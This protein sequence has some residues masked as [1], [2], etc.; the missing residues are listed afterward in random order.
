MNKQ[1]AQALLKNKEAIQAF[2]DYSQRPMHTDQKTYR[3]A[4]DWMEALFIVEGL[5]V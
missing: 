4:L 3:L 2:K 5:E 1:A